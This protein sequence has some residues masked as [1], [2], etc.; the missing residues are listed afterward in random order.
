MASVQ[1]IRICRKKQKQ[2][3]LNAKP[4][5]PYR[6]ALQI[7]SA[8]DRGGSNM[9]TAC[10]KIYT[11]DTHDK[12]CLPIPIYY[13]DRAVY[14]LWVL[15]VS[16]TGD[17]VTCMFSSEPA[18]IYIY[19]SFIRFIIALRPIITVLHKRNVNRLWNSPFIRCKYAEK[20]H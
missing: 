9:L 16:G 7:V 4:G 3:L 20:N 17:G 11:M 10:T 1:L 5:R 6:C 19:A 14:I 12:M 18:A 13:V 15:I 8:P 2:K